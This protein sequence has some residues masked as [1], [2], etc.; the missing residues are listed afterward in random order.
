METCYPAIGDELMSN[1]AFIP[2]TE[3]HTITIE[4]PDYQPAT[5]DVTELTGVMK[6]NWTG[7]PVD[8]TPSF[9]ADGWHQV[10]LTNDSKGNALDV[11]HVGNGKASFFYF[12][13]I[14]T[15]TPGQPEQ[16]TPTI[17]VW[18]EGTPAQGEPLI[19]NPDFIAAHCETT[20]PP[21]ECPPNKV[22]GWLDENGNPQGCVDNNPTPGQ[23]KPDNPQVVPEQPAIDVPPAIEQVT[24]QP[25]AT[26][27]ELALT[28]AGDMTGVALGALVL[29]AA[30]AALVKRA[31]SRA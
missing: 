26:H 4:N 16:G 19:A 28:G 5:E 12:E 31:A 14:Y 10:G 6:W 7:G 9:P 2:A 18:V 8:T 22:P 20:V 30:G 24:A 21:L 17:D 11:V 15:T 23:P 13:S 27:D 1:P 25:V 3:G 29:L